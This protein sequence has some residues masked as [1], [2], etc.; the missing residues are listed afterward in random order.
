MSN[1]SSPPSNPRAS[2]ARASL[3]RSLATLRAQGATLWQGLSARERAGLV[4][5]AVLLALA[6][7]W[8]GLLAPTLKLM[9]RYPQQWRNE[10][11]VLQSMQVW[12]QEAQRLKTVPAIPAAQ[13]KQWL[14][15]QQSAQNPAMRITLGADRISVLCK[16][17][18]AQELAG[19]LRDAR[20]NA[21]A[22]P[23][24][25]RLTADGAASTWSGEMVLVLPH[26]S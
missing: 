1:T 10:T 2:A 15:Q 22:L 4:S 26:A 8:W 19:W 14:Q 13:A 25:V 7:L 20:L 21:G 5:L 18:G 23:R 16:Q 24:E 9:Q 3:A 12:A 11:Q 6:V 17:L